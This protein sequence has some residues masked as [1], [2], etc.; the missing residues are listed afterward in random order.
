MSVCRTLFY[1]FCFTIL[2]FDASLHL[3]HATTDACKALLFAAETHNE[4]ILAGT[5]YSNGAFTYDNGAIIRAIEKNE[6][7]TA[8]CLVSENINIDWQEP[9]TLKTPLIYATEYG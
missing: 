3:A 5:P 8:L 9:D 4:D 2:L 7:P 6:E 1:V